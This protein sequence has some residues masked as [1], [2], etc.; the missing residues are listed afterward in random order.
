[1]FII[2]ETTFNCRIGQTSSVIVEGLICEYLNNPLG[3]DVTE[4]RL[5]WR[6]ESDQ[7]RQGQT[8]YRVLVSSTGEDITKNTGDFWDSG[9]VI[10]DKSVHIEYEGKSL[11]SCKRYYWKVRVWDRQGNPSSWSES[12]E[13]SMGILDPSGWT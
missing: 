10:T 7:N 9:K 8:A 11:E 1:L 12:V 6:L 13:W 2:F 5:S 3:I 4:P